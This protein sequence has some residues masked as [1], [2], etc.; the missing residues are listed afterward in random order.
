MFVVNGHAPSIRV[1]PG[2]GKVT[3]I[4]FV[5]A[6]GANAFPKFDFLDTYGAT[7]HELCGGRKSCGDL[8]V[9]W[10]AVPTA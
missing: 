6:Q 4:L 2:G 8:S 1:C 9:R 10:R 5:I 7:E 3:G